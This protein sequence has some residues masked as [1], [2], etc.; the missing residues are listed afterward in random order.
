M[1]SQESPKE[2]ALERFKPLLSP[3]E[4]EQLL[5]EL[6][7]PLDPAFRVNPL[8]AG[9]GAVHTWAERYGWD[10]HSVPYCDQG[11][12]VSG[13]DTNLSQTIEHRLGYYYIQDAASMLPVELFDWDELEEP[14]VLDLAASPGGKAISITPEQVIR[15]LALSSECILIF[16]KYWSQ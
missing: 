2:S 1:R 14:L 9:D 13:A 3:R 5:E 11:W 8:K 7:N 4:L 15:E 6:G 16:F 10:L 12:R